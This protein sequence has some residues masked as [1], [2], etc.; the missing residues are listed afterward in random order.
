M[1]ENGICIDGRLTKISEELT[2]EYDTGDFMRPWRIVAPSGQI[3]LTFT[4]LLER[5]AA[6]DLWLVKS[7]VHQM[8]GHYGGEVTTAGGATIHVRDLI[9][10]AEDHVAKW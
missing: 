7:E 1:T 8:F 4:P 5:V 9:G 2:W 6:S 3:D 10:W